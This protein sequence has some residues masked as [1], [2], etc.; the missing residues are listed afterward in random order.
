MD[1]LV[2]LPSEVKYGEFLVSCEKF[3]AI[4]LS[5]NSHPLEYSGDMRGII[6]QLDVSRASFA[7]L[8]LFLEGLQITYD[9][10]GLYTIV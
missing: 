3:R 9:V 1:I 5:V 7:G 8:Y 4:P 2:I 6:L 10:I